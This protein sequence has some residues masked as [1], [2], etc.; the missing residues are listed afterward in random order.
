MRI[1]G[2]LQSRFCS[3]PRP[4]RRQQLWRST[5][6]VTLSSRTPPAPSMFSDTDW[7]TTDLCAQCASIDLEMV[8]TEDSSM[9]LR[10]SDLN[11]KYSR[12]PMLHFFLSCIADHNNTSAP[13]ASSV[14]ETSGSLL[15]H[16][17]STSIDP[18]QKGLRVYL[19][20]G[21][22]SQGVGFSI[23]DG[24]PSGEGMLRVRRLFKDTIDY[25]MIRKWIEWCQETHLDFCAQTRNLT[26]ERL[27]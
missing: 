21:S 4:I 8:A 14:P 15:L 16:H 3:L 1:C 17:T 10:M 11:E 6:F 2:P 24:W 12:C 26:E 20:M 18:S 13:S 22:E 5:I 27:P 25:G 7:N 9:T 23:M 19:Q